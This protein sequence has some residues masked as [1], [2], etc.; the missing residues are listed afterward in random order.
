MRIA[1]LA[2]ITLAALTPAPSVLAQGT[3]QQRSDCM[4]DAFKFCSSDIPFV[5]KIEACLE[6]NMNQLSPACRS[7]FAP[8]KKT[9]LRA[10][11][12]R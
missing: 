4:A 3:S 2:F 6:S 11:H 8:A 1:L 7:E 9:R 10:E 12:F 5:S